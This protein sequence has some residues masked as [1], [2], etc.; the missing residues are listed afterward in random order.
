MHFGRRPPACLP[1]IVMCGTNYK[2]GPGFLGSGSRGARPERRVDRD[3]QQRLRLSG[4]ARAGASGQKAVVRGA[5]RRTALRLEDFEL[6]ELQR[7][8]RRPARANPNGIL[9]R[10]GRPAVKIKAWAKPASNCRRT[11]QRSLS[12]LGLAPASPARF[13]KSSASK[14]ESWALNPPATRLRRQLS[15][16]PR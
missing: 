16:M 14:C 12:P 5:E 9:N 11:T 8:Q 1:V 6:A 4:N 13:A 7:P 10:C 15:K 3:S 2:S